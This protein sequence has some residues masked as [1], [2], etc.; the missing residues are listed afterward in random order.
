M[1]FLDH[2]FN[3]LVVGPSGTGKTTF[4]SYYA[5]K[6]H[7]VHKST[8]YWL[9]FPSIEPHLRELLPKWIHTTTDLLDPGFAGG[10]LSPSRQFVVGDEI[11]RLISKYDHAK[12]EGRSFVDLVGIHRHKNFDLLVSDQVFDFLKGVRTRAHWVVFTGLNDTLY[13][14]LRDHLSPR[15]MF[16][17]E[18]YQPELVRL[19]LQNRESIPKGK[20][21]VVVSNG[22]RTFMVN[23]ERPKWFTEDI[24]TIWRV[25][26]PEDLKK[27]HPEED[28]SLSDYDYRSAFHE[29]LM[30][31][32]HLARKVF[33]DK[34]TKEK[35]SA[36]FLLTSELVYGGPKKLPDGGRGI[37]ELLL[38]AHK[39]CPYCDSPALYEER[40]RSLKKSLLSSRVK[41]PKEVSRLEQEVS[42]LIGGN[43]G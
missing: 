38:V 43:D 9:T 29:S 20:G 27:D 7:R 39:H 21:R 32:Y 14:S 22:T 4:L 34:L 12:K 41:V 26:T 3:Y 31:A 1:R 5:D 8:G 13:F 25:V 37:P 10:H 17:L 16:F 36:M 18:R 24:S 19:G 6:H 40:L 28:E 2:C 30:L 23:F 35:L 33:G 42:S 15:L 11:N